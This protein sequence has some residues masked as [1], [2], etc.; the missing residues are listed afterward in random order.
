MRAEIVSVGTELLLGQIVDTDA[1]YLS[2]T[3]SEFGIDLHFRVTVGD[4]AGRLADALR[5]ALSRSDLVFT[6]GG[7]GPTQDDLTKE[8]VAEVVGDEMVLDEECA[9]RLR[10]FFAARGVDMPENNL[11]QALVPTKGMALANPLGTAPGA[12]FEAEGGKAIIILPGPPREFTAM[13]DAAVVPYLRD[14]VGKDASVIK[15]RVLRIAGLGESSVEDRIKHL[16]G[17]SNPT[18]APYAKPG[19]VEVRITAKASRVEEAE[20]MIDEMDRKLVEVLGDRVFGRDEETLEQIVVRE[21]IS[22]KLTLATAE[23]CTG[24]LISDRITDVPG[25]S[26]AFLMGVVS[27]S[28]EAKKRVLG[29][30]AELLEKNG[31]V[32]DEVA[33]AM[34]D[35][36]RKISGADIG[37][38][39]TGIAGPTGGSPQKPVGLVYIGLSSV[40][41]TVAHK[42]QFPGGRIDIKLRASQAALDMLR[43]SL[44]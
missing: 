22:R 5:L 24:G 30:P 1:A 20:A 33:R 35:G 18:V 9:D 2:R 27:Y 36:V 41:E 3:L 26:A 16:I 19:A 7:L 32:S 23:S 28:N 6:I 42:Y 21:L 14:R 29:V 12:V 8:T 31:A 43:T 13:V 25:S 38:S 15:S 17:G 10:Q 40:T 39:V 37:I 44:A 34:A 11:K 4:N